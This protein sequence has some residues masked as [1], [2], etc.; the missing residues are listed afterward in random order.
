LLNK[1]RNGVPV[2]TRAMNFS[3]VDAV[4]LS[5]VPW[6]DDRPTMAKIDRLP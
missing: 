1:R 4:L 2:V 3:H 5:N 6:P